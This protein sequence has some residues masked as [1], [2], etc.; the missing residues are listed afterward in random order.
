MKRR[1]EEAA[2]ALLVVKIE[3]P[4]RI[5]ENCRMRIR[6]LHVGPETTTSLHLRL[7]NYF[8]T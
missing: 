3:A 5:W 2:I 4:G 6:S 1:S 8:V 7:R